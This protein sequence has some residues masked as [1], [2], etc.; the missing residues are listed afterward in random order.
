[1][2]N[3]KYK[4]L[5]SDTLVFALGSF[6]SKIITFLLVPLYTNVLSTEQ[7]GIAD[8]V[9]TCAN[10]IVPIISLVIQ[11]AVLRFGLSRKND[12]GSV[13]KCA[14]IVFFL[15]SVV[16]FLLTPVAGLYGAVSEWKYYLLTISITNMASNIMYSY[17]KACEKNK[18]YAISS[19]VQ[20]AILATVNILLLV[21]FPC[22]IRGYLLAN[23]IAHIAAVIVML[24]ATKG[25]RDILSAPF[26]G[27]LM[28]QM[29]L[30]SLPLIAN[31]LSWWVLNSSDRVMIEYY[32]SSSDL[33]LYTAASKIPAL[34]SVITAIFS[35]AWTISAI[36]EYDSDKDKQFY[37]NV[38]QIF[39]LAMFLGA[40]LIILVAKPFMHIYVG[41][42]FFDAWV[43]VPLLISGAIYYAFSAF[44]GAIYGALKKNIRV[45]LTTALAA[46]INIAIN[47]FLLSKI[48][49]IAAALSTMI[50]Y[51]VIG[52]YRMLD[53]Q[54]Y[55]RFKINYIRYFVNSIIVIAQ[56]VLV[57]LDFYV[58]V[59]S[60]IA[61]VLLLIVNKSDITSLAGVVKGKAARLLRR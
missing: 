55:F 48:G 60:A 4:T 11:D 20:T 29:V 44:F 33:G 56:T 22:G 34:L 10:F 61:I 42:E 13:L 53:I 16:A 41:D 23:I 24:V 8:L 35:Q 9:A 25:I 43:M 59:S 37:S 26:D 57:T 31:N 40:S 50:G 30:Y 3:N 6:G 47:F 39:S 46:I 38:F 28:K 19:I 2:Q 32:C 17:A 45:A 5:F 49:V 18:L 58:Y 54:K 1:M 7:Y 14:A 12:Q 15:G 36:K 52:V 51:L 21:V 27:Q